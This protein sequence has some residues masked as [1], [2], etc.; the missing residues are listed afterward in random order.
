MAAISKAVHQKFLLALEER[1]PQVSEPFVSLLQSE[2]SRLETIYADYL[3][4]IQTAQQLIVKYERQQKNIRTE[5]RRQ[6]SRTK[7]KPG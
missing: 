3:Q 2:V 5:L 1:L 4:H 6:Q 7:E